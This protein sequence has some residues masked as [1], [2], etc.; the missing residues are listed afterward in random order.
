MNNNTNST[1]NMMPGKSSLKNHFTLVVIFLGI[2]LNLLAV[3]ILYRPTAAG[4]YIRS[5]LHYTQTMV[6]VS[7]LILCKLYF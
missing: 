3:I 2:I 7:N 6:T 1:V 5:N 4:T